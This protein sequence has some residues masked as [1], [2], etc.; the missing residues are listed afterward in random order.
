M[1]EDLFHPPA[2][3]WTFVHKARVVQA[4]AAGRLTLVEVVNAGISVEEFV[5]WQQAL[6]AY[7]QLG[8]RATDPFP[9][10]RETIRR[11]MTY[12]CADLGVAYLLSPEGAAIT[13]GR[14]GM[15]SYNPHDVAARY[16]GHCHVFH[17]DR[18]GG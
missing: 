9:L 14:C 3:R 6:A 12:L 15:T 10:S 18:E 13:C 2:G 4:V 16:C 1:A 7:G 11:A 8:L 5:G 17:E